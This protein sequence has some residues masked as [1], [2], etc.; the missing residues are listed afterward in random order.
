MKKLNLFILSVCAVFVLTNCQKTE[1]PGETA[2]AKFSNDWWAVLYDT[3]GNQLTDPAKIVTTNTANDKDS[4][5]VDDQQHI[6]GF[7]V[8]AGVDHQ[9][10]T[11]AA[12]NSY[13]LYYDPAHPAKFPLSVSITDGK[14]F[15]NGGHSK[16][17][18]ITDSIYMKIE[19]SD[20]PGTI[21]SIRGVASTNRAED[22]Y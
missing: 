13:N 5:Y 15:P 7:F 6:W 10:L 12:T 8:K 16:T 2:T 22:D 18:I 4:I 17:G 19:F 9:N 11:F 20:D 3:D 1:E 14:V 21:Y